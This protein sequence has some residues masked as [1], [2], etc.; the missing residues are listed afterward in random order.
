M[1]QAAKATGQI[2]KTNTL[3]RDHIPDENMM[4]TLKKVGIDPKL[5]MR[6]QR[7]ASVPTDEFDGALKDSHDESCD[8]QDREGNVQK[9]SHDENCDVQN[10]QK[11]AEKNIQHEYSDMQNTEE[12]A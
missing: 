11:N 4:F 9:D 3:H 10:R 5:S 7:I 6:A 1:L 12:N 8:V 2:S